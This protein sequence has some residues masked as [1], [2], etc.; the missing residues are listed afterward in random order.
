MRCPNCR[1]KNP[2]GYFYCV[3]CGQLLRP[4][5]G[6]KRFATVLFFDLSGF[7]HFTHGHGPERAWEEVERA[8]ATARRAIARHGGR[9]HATFGDGLMA[10]FGLERSRGKREVWH[11][12]SAALETVSE[13]EA[14]VDS[15][16]LGL[17]GRAVV[18]SG[19][20]FVVPKEK[21]PDLLGDPVNRAH[22]LIAAA[23]PGAVYLDQ[24]TLALAPEAHVEPLDPIRAKGF[25][26]PLK[27]YRLVGFRPPGREPL[28]ERPLAEL[29]RRWEAAQAGRPRVAVLTGPPGVGKHLVLEALRRSLPE[30][31]VL[32]PPPFTPG[33]T[34]R[35]W[36]QAHL[37]GNPGFRQE[38][39]SHARDTGTLE[40]LAAALGEGPERVPGDRLGPAVLALLEALS[41]V[42]FLLV[43]PNLHHAPRALVAFLRE[44]ERRGRGRYLVVATARTGRYPGRIPLRPLD[45]AEGLAAL[46]RLWPEWPLYRREELLARS[47]G[48]AGLLAALVRVP[49]DEGLAA[50]FQPLFDALPARAREVLSLAA[51]L[52][53]PPDPE[54][55]AA[56]V[57]P[58]AEEA[59]GRL[60]TDGFLVKEPGGAL[61]FAHPVYRRAVR[62]LVPEKRLRIW[63]RAVAEVRLR[64]GRALEAAR[65]FQL[66]GNPGAAIRVLRALAR[67]ADDEGALRLLR[68]AK[69]LARTR[70]QERP[71]RL[72]LAERLVERDP[73]A[74]LA[75]LKDLPGPRAAY[76]RARA[77]A[78][79]GHEETAR[80][81][82]R[83]YLEAR[84]DDREAWRRFLPLAGRDDLE[85]A[86]GRLPPDPELEARAGGRLAALGD[87]EAAAGW[88]ERAAERL[89]SSHP[90]RAARLAL[91]LAGL[92][93]RRFLPKAAR[94]WAER[95]Y[96]AAGEPATR[97]LAEAVLGSLALDL[98]DLETAT[99][100]IR[101]AAERLAELPPGEAHARVAGIR[102]RLLIETG[103]VAE[104]A[105]EGSRY[106][107]RNDH[108]WLGAMA[109]LAAA[110]DGQAEA[111]LK[112]STERWERADTD[113][114][115]A[116]LALAR[117]FAL[118]KLRLD[119]KAAFLQAF[120]LARSAQN[121]YGLY[122]SL[123]ALAVYHREANPSRTDAL[124]TY[125]LKRTWR[126]G[127]LPFHHLA[128]LLKA[129]ASLRAG[130]PVLHLLRFESPFGVLEFWR[131]SLVRAAGGE[132]PAFPREALFGYGI[133]GRYAWHV[134]ERVW[135]PER[136]SGPAS[137]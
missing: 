5:P 66:A 42:P 36:L 90:E 108:P 103:R 60:L 87:L 104:A 44:V 19:F 95:A 70:A 35:E 119:P 116:F 14:Q 83:A 94:R 78:A 55:L 41:A 26:E 131:R 79:L 56:L 54:T 59:V 72:E 110:L 92:G 63:H 91:E 21:G 73:A 111:A 53:A 77:E 2:E 11:A 28:V 122:L 30:V 80:S 4:P 115:R 134:W 71:V 61:A 25:P 17:K 3:Y 124:A 58:A 46:A 127:F 69:A 48:L 123:A 106:L 93:W 105:A 129:E 99:R 39:F 68:Q 85:A 114:S 117:A 8:N 67:S 74:A 121:P 37:R 38:L 125:L 98:G 120:R 52:E 107:D 128:R 132:A 126:Q 84:P 101:A 33:M 32:E 9:V 65:H 1:R 57:G 64:Q 47:G 34:L 96:R 97:T 81:L 76:L 75:E 22:R 88:L 112:A 89:W 62:A 27:A 109:A 133:L 86:R 13:V 6:E 12:L 137:A 45:R 100:R 18:T 136:K 29:L 10:L 113:H 23:P 82:F 135:T 130:H 40:V 51:A 118:T 24:T 15:G 102:L 49:G 50:A 31:R 20:V 7:T 16:E 43:L